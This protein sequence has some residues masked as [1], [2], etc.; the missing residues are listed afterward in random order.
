MRRKKKHQTHNDSHRWVIS[1]ADFITLLFAF[2]VVM[3][4]MSSVNVSKYKSLS[5]GMNSAFNKKDGAKSVV[6]TD[7]QKDGRQEI[8]SRGT[9]N[10]G[11]D[12]LS[13]LLSDLEDS[14]YHI[15]RQD[16]LIELQIK[17]GSM[18]D[19][20]GSELNA[21]TTI[22][23]MKLAAKLKKSPYPILIEG[24]TDNVPITSLQYPSNWELS[25]ARAATVGRVLNSYGV[26]PERLSVTGYGELYPIME[27]V[28]E[29]GRS[30]NRRVSILI[31]KDRTNPR[32]L[33]P[34]MGQMHQSIMN[35]IQPKPEKK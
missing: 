15:Y 21:D 18:F 7:T 16:G 20:A 1:Y 17:A 8:Q 11:L 14:D 30:Q 23:L 26:D 22:K 9:F 34:E 13:K 25:A 5:D 31:V 33:N 10:D 29:I 28:T 12:E 24:Y 2:F 19:S 6:S 27:N 3:Y 32:I 4:A 35:D